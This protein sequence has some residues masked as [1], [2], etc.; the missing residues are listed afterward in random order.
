MRTILPGPGLRAA[1]ACALFALAAACGSGEEASYVLRPA[2]GAVAEVPRWTVEHQ[3]LVIGRMA[4]DDAGTSGWALATDGRAFRLSAGRWS[5]DER[6]GALASGGVRSLH[7]SRDGRT[8][9][10]FTPRGVLRYAAGRWVVADTSVRAQTAWVSPDGAR[11]WAF[12]PGANYEL[13]GGRWIWRSAGAFP[14]SLAAPSLVAMNDE[15]TAGWVYGS[16][17]GTIVRYAEGRWTVF[18]DTVVPVL[19][20][21]SPGG[22]VAMDFE[23]QMWRDSAGGWVLLDRARAGTAADVWLAPGGAWGWMADYRGVFRWE[24]GRALVPVL[25]VRRGAS[26][27]WMSSDGSRG[28]VF[29]SGGIVGRFADGRW[30]AENPLHGFEGRFGGANFNVVW[31]DAEGSRGWAVGSEGLVAR[32]EDGEWRRD[33]VPAALRG[34]HFTRLAMNREGTAG[35]VASSDGEVF[36]IEDGRWSAVR[37]PEGGLPIRCLAT[38]GGGETAYVA[39]GRGSA[40]L[41]GD[42]WR[43]SGDGWTPLAEGSSTAPRVFDCVWVDRRSGELLLRT[44]GRVSRYRA[45]GSRLTP[46][47]AG[48]TTFY[49]SLDFGEDGAAGSGITRDRRILRWDTGSGDT[50]ST[51]PLP[52]GGGRIAGAPLWVDARGRRAVLLE[53]PLARHLLNGR[54]VADSLPAFRGNWG[55]LWVHPSGRHGWAVGDRGTVL[56]MGTAPLPAAEL[57]VPRGSSLEEFSGDLVLRVAAGR[58]SLHLRG[59][60]VTGCSDPA[61]ALSAPAHY[62]VERDA[63]G[64]LRLRF[65]GALREQVLSRY[66]GSRC[67]LRFH[68]AFG[69]TTDPPVVVPLEHAFHVRGRPAWQIAAAG[70]AGLLLLNLLLVLAATR[71][72]WLRGVILS[73][74]GAGLVGLV[75]GK[76]LVIEPLV[77]HVRPIRLAMFRDYRRGLRLSPAVERWTEREYIPPGV[78][79][80]EDAPGTAQEGEPWAAVFERIC[81][82]PR[83]RVWLVEGPSGLGK[84]ALLERWTALALERGRTPLLLRLASRRPAPGEAATVLAQH[85]GLRLG[86]DAVLALLEA[87]GFVLLLDG[88]NEDRDPEATRDFV[89]RTSGRN[90]VVVSSQSDPGWG[91]DLHVERVRLSRFGRAQLLRLLSPEWVDRLLG[92]AHLR[93][94]AGLPQTAQLAAAFIRRHGRLPAAQVELYES[95]RGALPPGSERANLDA[96]AWALFRENAILLPEDETRLSAPFLAAA[97]E[98]GV[99]TVS[100]VDG[101]RR[102]RFVHER[103]HRFFTACHLAPQDP[104]PLAEWHAELRAGLPRAHWREVLEPWSEMLARE[105]HAG[106]LPA[107]RYEDFLRGVAAFD[108]ALFRVLYRQTDRFAAAGLVSLTPRFVADAARVL[109][110]EPGP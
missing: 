18:T 38:T 78:A 25:P 23:G 32:Y 14:S 65:A 87:G 70:V 80:A 108:A 8:G 103:V 86:E 88:L 42:V 92:A 46:V 45:E 48:D 16:L 47:A 43:V 34:R 40:D 64:R 96:T 41:D 94:A 81:T 73:P 31:M 39:V 69:G 100:V 4:L 51:P 102:H 68:L 19:L 91:G 106:T 1:F 95:L 9:W 72:R 77:R 6:L 57:A 33:T 7:L 21:A 109:A 98:A 59:I 105:V 20:H 50:V 28:V 12:T 5:L 63:P 79:V 13:T 82:A 66:A 93:E 110:G 27:I 71:S 61:L 75:V 29:G 36:R 74:A 85:G 97:V 24:R 62:A 10:A 30:R 11:G 56:R 3:G 58:D 35:W 104:R 2:E 37:P 26:R 83:G 22:I 99:L 49:W 55:G 60:D 54:W 15:G 90:T 52:E 76:Y 44:S 84:T 53:G 101:R 67:T 107:G 17:P 89:R